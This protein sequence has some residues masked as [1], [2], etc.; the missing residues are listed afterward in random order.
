MLLMFQQ[1][2]TNNHHIHSG[3]MD[4]G[5][6]SYFTTNCKCLQAFFLLAL[7]SFVSLCKGTMGGRHLSVAD[8]QMSDKDLPMSLGMNSAILI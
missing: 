1:S 8:M 3:K 7:W 2:P 6:V 4:I 5:L